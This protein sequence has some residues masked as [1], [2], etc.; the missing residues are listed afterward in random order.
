VA[1]SEPGRP[2]AERS[3]SERWRSERSRTARPKLGRE[4][5]VAAALAVADVD[6]LDAVTI[7]RLAQELQVT[8]MALYWHFK[9]KDALLGALA[10]HI[11]DQAVIQ[12]RAAGNATHP[13]GAVQPEEIS[14]AEP[15]GD[16]GGWAALRIVLAALVGAM[17]RHPAVAAL[18]P[19]RVLE[20]ASGLWVTEHALGILHEQGLEP[21]LAA[22]MAH[23]A[24]AS[25]VMIVTSQPG[26]D[27]PELD[28]RTEMGRRKRIALASLPPDRYPHVVASAEYFTACEAPERYF[29]GGIEFVIAGVRAQAPGHA[30]T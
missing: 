21:A 20:C 9:D 22:E 18:V 27:I 1:E 15:P 23:F 12:I 2:K 19:T 3:K 11:W 28:A 30:G 14:G 25:A 6:G 7:R 13:G 10:D 4:V 17:R 29:E 26:S 16:E 5:V 24:L 8:P